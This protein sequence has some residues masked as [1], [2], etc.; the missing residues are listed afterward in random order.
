M[1]TI[2]KAHEVNQGHEWGLAKWPMKNW[3]IGFANVSGWRT[4][5]TEADDQGAGAS[6]PPVMPV[7]QKLDRGLMRISLANR[8][9]C[10][11]SVFR[12]LAQ[13][14][15]T[16]PVDTGIRANLGG[17]LSFRNYRKQPLN[18]FKSCMWLICKDFSP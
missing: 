9:W 6:S 2:P 16:P 14:T 18:T 8:H 3:L 4:R 1:L 5:S 15:T 11:N 7:V 13:K 10:P 12:L 17:L